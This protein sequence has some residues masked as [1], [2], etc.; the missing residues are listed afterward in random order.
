MTRVS[1]VMPTFNR[2]AQLEAALR[3]LADQRTD[4][5]DLQVVVVSDGS[6]DDTDSYLRS[7]AVPLPV[8]VVA[9][10]NQGVAAARNA[11]VAAAD[12]DLLLFLDDDVVAERGCV[13]AHVAAHA[14]SST[15]GVVI[16]PLLTP[17]DANF[18]PWVLWEQKQLY[19]QYSA[20]RR[21]DWAPTARQFYTGNASLSRSVFIDSGGFDERYRRAEDIE[22]AFRLADRGL[23]FSFDFAARALHYPQ[24]SFE[25][26][27]SI[28]EQYGRND[29]K[30]WRGG[31]EWVLPMVR[32][33]HQQRHWLNRLFSGAALRFPRIVGLA[34]LTRPLACATTRLGIGRIG[35][36]ALSATYNMTYQRA[37]VDELGGLDR[38][39]EIE[40][41]DAGDELMAR[42][43]G[44]VLHA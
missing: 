32:S 7:D 40:P 30:F 36:M 8:I 5:F 26:W 42:T 34:R 35:Q 39:F 17:D 27:L 11:G 2:R 16:G 33:H 44:Q 41:S 24:R 28:P 12:G 38:F 15:D 9:Q 18:E 31:H 4:G 29:V 43:G 22:L 6:T 1:V 10:E 14:E 23:R 37:L 3:A 20:M 19:K 21:G 13:A 25:S